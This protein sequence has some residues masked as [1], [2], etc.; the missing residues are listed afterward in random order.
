MPIMSPTQLRNGILAGL[1]ARVP[2]L[3]SVLDESL[4]SALAVAERETE[5]E[6]GTRMAI[7][8]LRPWTG[9]AAPPVVSGEETEGTYPWPGII[10]GDG[11]I[12]IR[13]R[14]R[15]IVSVEAMLLKVPGSLITSLTV[16]LEWLNIDRRG[17]EITIAPT[18]GTSILGSFMGGVGGNALLPGRIPHTVF[19]T[20]HAGLGVEGLRTWPQVRRLVELK[21]ALYLLAEWSISINPTGI[22][23]MSADGLSQSRSSGYVFK[24]LE[25]RLRNEANSLRDQIIG[26]WDGPFL[27]VL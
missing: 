17:Q 20:Y 8:T 13:P 9:A 1:L 2:A 24:D 25:E 4:S 11:F 27:A 18:S 21:T 14:I 12:R 19:L 23:N 3:S 5:V 26:V 16:P 22:S 6:L 10:P 7:T 15:P